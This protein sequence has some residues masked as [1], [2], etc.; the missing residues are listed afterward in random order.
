MQRTAEVVRDYVTIRTPSGGY[1]VKR[2]VSPGVVVQPG[3]PILKIAQLDRVRLQAN[4]SERDVAAIRVGS[5][6]VV[7]A[8]T[9]GTPP[10]T[11]RVTAVFPFVD[12]GSRTAVVEAVVDNAG[13][14]YLPGQYVAMEFVTGQQAGAVS[15]PRGAV[16][17]HGGKATVWVVREGRAEPREVATGLENAERVQV[18]RGVAAGERL[19]V[20]GRDGLYAGARVTEVAAAAP[21]SGASAPGTVT[22]P[23]S[24]ARGSTPDAAGPANTK[25]GGHAGH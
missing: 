6:V 17:H 5:P 15:V 16:A 9:A 23:G 25:E 3:M 20:R 7:T 18:V 4:V 11:A 24:P 12:A 14:R 8:P 21:A 10:L 2:L 13:R 22:P 19:V 1:V